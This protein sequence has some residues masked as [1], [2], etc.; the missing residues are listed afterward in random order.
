M[1][2]YQIRVHATGPVFDGRADAAADDAIEQMKDDVAQ[3]AYANVMTNLSASIRN[4]TP[5]YET[6]IIVQSASAD[7][8]VHDR[9]IIYGP[10]LEGDGSHN[11]PATSFPGY[12]SF[13]RAAQQTERD[14]PAIITRTLQPY[15][16]RMQ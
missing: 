14:A 1:T 15:L 3:Q 2:V 7:R 9:G 5:Y 4:P 12:H 8:I 11:A 13:R 10:W 6:Q 16:R